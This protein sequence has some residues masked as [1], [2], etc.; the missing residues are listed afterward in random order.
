MRRALAIAALASLLV[1]PAA[2]AK[3]TLRFD[4]PAAKAGQ[5]VTVIGAGYLAG[6]RRGPWRL[7]LVR[8]P[9]L[10]L[11]LYPPYGG[12]FRYVPPRDIRLHRLGTIPRLP[13]RHVL[14]L[15]SMPPGRYGLIAWCSGCGDQPPQASHYQGVPDDA[16]L[17]WRGE[18]LT[19]RR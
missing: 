17:R 8:A 15:P 10:A 14:P 3:L 1:A 7:Y 13:G 19:V 4:R 9:L 16:T 12:G 5:R 6:D 18:L 2:V 11:A